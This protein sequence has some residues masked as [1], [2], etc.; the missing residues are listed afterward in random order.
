M[1][2]QLLLCVKHQENKDDYIKSDI[3]IY[4]DKYKVAAHKIWQLGTILDLNTYVFKL[5]KRMPDK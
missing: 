1:I 3:Q 2:I 4:V 5:V